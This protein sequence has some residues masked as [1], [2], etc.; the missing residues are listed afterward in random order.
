M[1][2]SA[3]RK[4]IGLELKLEAAFFAVPLITAIIYQEKQGWYYLAVALCCL[5]LG[6]ILSHRKAEHRTI[7]AKE[8]FVAVG[9]GWVVMSFFGALPFILSGEI[10][11]FVDAMFETISGFTTT[12][13]SI[14]TDVEA[15]THTALI[16]RSFTH[17]IGGMGVMVFILMILPKGGAYNM[18]I[19]RAESPGPS[20]GKLVPRIKDTA[21][22]LYAIYIAMTIIEAIL[23]LLAG[24]PL[25]D[26]LCTSFGT[27]GTGG[28]GIKRDSF[29][30]YSVL[31]QVITAVF[32]I[33]FGVNFNAYYYLRKK[34]DR[35]NIL[36][37]EEV[38]VYFII[39]VVAVL[40]ITFDILSMCTSFGD[41]LNKAFFQVGSIITTTGFA[42]A[43]F[44]LWPSLSKT[45]LVTIMFCGACAGSTGGGI[46]VSRI[47]ILLKS[48]VFEI[49][50]Y[51]HPNRINTIKLDGKTLDKGVI[52]G[53]TGYLTTYAAIFIA[54]LLLISLNNFDFTTNFTAVT[55]TFNNIGPGLEMVGPTGSFADF[56]A[57]S[58]IVFMFDM[59]AGRLELYP[60]LILFY[61]KIWT[62]NV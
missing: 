16:W 2:H 19:M 47:V 31:I 57:L 15:L 5:A 34:E 18:H 24:M 4:I 38:K 44:N 25:F 41:A 7:F 26:S 12:G 13:A 56:N 30:S 1:N 14:L 3:I 50:R 28:F 51:T 23:L 53:V 62:K 45:I 52:K 42:T 37:M 11:S 27:A 21:T 32:M 17:W 6:F 35:K 46:K 58:K 10:P 60:M 33:L 54:S 8:G 55:A 43:D 36:K 29:A 39:I 20:V 40:I 61:P 49:K 48:V 59:L 9:L 22:I